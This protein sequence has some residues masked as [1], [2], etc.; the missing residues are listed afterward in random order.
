MGRLGWC[1]VAAVALL[2]AGAEALAAPKG[3]P[4]RFIVK[5]R[6]GLVAASS[7]AQAAGRGYRFGPAFGHGRFRTVQ[8]PPGLPAQKV[9]EQLSRL[10]QVEY[11]EPDHW[12][13][14]VWVPND[15]LWSKQWNFRLIGVDDAWDVIQGG[16]PSVVVAVVDTGVAYEDYGVYRKAPDFSGTVFV[17]GYDFVNDDPHPNDDN[18]HGTHVAG[19]IAETTDNGE[20]VSGIAFR[21]AVMPLKALGSDGT[22]LYSDVVRAIYWA[23]DHGAQV[24]NLSITGDEPSSALYDALRY[25][26]G[27]DV[28]VVAAVGND[29][30]PVGYPARYNDVCISVGAVGSN[31]LRAPYS[32][33]G[34]TLDLVAPGGGVG[35]GIVQQ[36]LYMRN[37]AYFTYQSWSGT[38]MA[39]PHVS[40]AA[41]LLK[42]LGVSS[43][44]EVESILVA[45]ATDKGIAGWDAYYGYGLVNVGAAVAASGGTPPPPPPP[46]EPPPEPP[47]EGGIVIDDGDAGTWSQGVWS[48]SSVAGGYDGDSLYTSGYD[49]D[50]YR[51]MPSLPA[52]GEYEVYLWWV[53]SR[54]R[55]TR[56]PVRVRH[57]AGIWQGEVDQTQNGSR[58]NYLGTW[59]FPAGMIGYVEVSGENG[60]ASADA[61]RFVAVEGP[62][63]NPPEPQD[64]AAET[65]EDTS[66]EVDVLANDSDPDGDALSLVSVDAPLH[67]TAEVQGNRVL[68]TPAPDYW[69]EDGFAYTVDDGH[70]GTAQARVSVNVLPVN[71]AP[72]PQDDTASTVEGQA[73]EIVV[74]ANDADPDGDAMSVVS[75]TSPSTGVAEVVS[76]STVRYTPDPG[77]VGED[78]FSYEVTD[79]DGAVGTAQVVVTVASATPPGPSV[80]VVLD[81]GDPGT[82]SGG[83]WRQSSIAGG[84]GDSLY[85][86]G[87]PTDWYRWAPD[88]PIAGSYDVYLWWT[89]SG[90]RSSRVPVLVSHAGGTSELEV[91]QTTN[92][93]TWNLLGRWTFDA[94]SSG[95]VEISGKNG[96]ASADAV[97][98]VSAGGAPPPEPPPP[99]PPPPEPEPSPTV[100]VVV[101]NGDPGTES[102][103][104]WF[105]SHAPQ[106][107]GV[108]S[109]YCSGRPGDTYRWTPNL[110][111]D[112]RY[113][114]LLWWTQGAGRSTRV[115]V[116]VGHAAG[117]YQ[118]TVDQTQNG[119]QWN[120]IGEWDFFQGTGGYVKI[121]G[122]NGQA[123]A[124]AV[125]F[126]RVGDLSI[127]PP[128]PPPEP[129][130][131]E[132]PP[133][134]GEA[135]VMDDG[136][137]GT[138]Q[139][140]VWRPSSAPGGHD[141]DSLYCP[142]YGT[143][144]YRWTPLLPAA[145]EYDVYL[146]WTSS[147]G[148]SARVPVRVGHAD[149]V[150][151]T[152]VDQRTGGGVWQH[153]GRWRFDAGEAGYVEVTGE[154]GQASADAVRFVP[155]TP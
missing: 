42:A 136:D 113:Q 128:E 10:P 28:V 140:G 6:S 102:T 22:G 93:S 62:G 8:A 57:A 78:R 83:L 7:L 38:S 35:E 99:E 114:V 40:A 108:D 55:S 146:W 3:P 135:V 66:V 84:G 73:V 92:G 129:P 107:Y 95:Y 18:G 118:T 139:S 33:Y 132:P 111:E 97:R 11:V 81:D 70:G 25:A 150:W 71:D 130:P 147:A 109:L 123:S 51:W 61:V 63:N 72:R 94:G 133:S 13:R 155:V 116:I 110:P 64:D 145:G 36:T 37:P 82:T 60:Q 125:L 5:T 52:S 9:L 142:G 144:R 124:D 1:S 68:Y 4:G 21:S 47:P 138:T 65:P 12:I 85:C 75:V 100:S 151:E 127:P 69:G 58:W 67:G 143:D 96:Q 91:D 141:G 20:G 76:A 101:D 24:I 46:S 26:W 104:Y 2:L 154:N 105:V 88:L 79:P 106:P 149:G 39:A 14:A 120:L 54:G 23:V 117:Q 153:L 122:E 31:G 137:P 32:N 16:D 34:P 44:A 77:F 27:R 15:P 80:E 121:T 56:V 45:T 41:A 86:V 59:T 43:A 49:G 90:G 87:Y 131:P 119:G 48:P 17:P 134:G 29:A 50:V 152:T 115:P 126:V 103:G 98:F 89:A 30:G 19:T 53:A 112:G 74:T 148:R